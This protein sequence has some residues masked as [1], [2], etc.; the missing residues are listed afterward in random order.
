MA[1]RQESAGESLRLLYVAL[2]RASC[3]VVAHWAPSSS[4]TPE[5]PLHRVLCARRDGHQRPALAYPV[6]EPPTRAVAGSPWVA[7]E[8][9]EHPSPIRRWTPRQPPEPELAV[10]PYSRIPD[11]TWRRTSYTGLT[12]AAHGAERAP[13]GTRV[14][15]PEDV[16]LLD[17]DVA[18][19]PAPQIESAF[20]DLP[21]GAA[22]GTTV[23]EILERVD[24]AAHELTA[25]VQ[26][27]SREVLLAHPMPDVDPDRLARAIETALRTPLGPL[28]DHRPLTGF[29]RSQRLAELDFELP[30]GNRSTSHDGGIAGHLTPTLADVADLMRRHLAPNDPLVDYPEHLVA[31]GLGTATLRGYLAGSIDAVLR[32]PGRDGPSFLVVDYKTNVLRNPAAPE[33]ARLAWGYRPEVLPAAMIGSHY[34]LQ[35]LLY[36]VA[37]HRYLRWRLPGYTPSR[38]LGG[39]LYL[40]L[41]GMTGAQTPTQGGLPCGVFSWHPP[42]DL[43]VDVSDLLNGGPG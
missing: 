12:S 36:D 3:L 40:F 20:A 22:F 27:H 41:R 8:T 25:E 26:I 24:A 18:A 5:A 13:T 1:H 9:V 29:P 31:A 2:T 43:V 11:T 42:A 32:V 23:H 37:L 14:D 28:G 7:V 4:N 39:V 34:P 16:E 6:A 15:E 17:D 33:L 19:A 35:A 38:H 21:S 30:L 10:A